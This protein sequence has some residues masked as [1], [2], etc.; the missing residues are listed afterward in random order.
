[1][2]D[3][4]DSILEIAKNCRHC[5]MC[6]VDFLNK[7]ICPAGLQKHY[8]SFYPVG[9]MDVYAGLIENTIPVTEKCLEIADS[10]NLCGKCDYQCY[11]VNELR[12]SKVM[13][14]LKDYIRVYLKNGGKII[15]TKDDEILLELKKVVGDFWA[16]NDPAIKI[17]YHHDL[18]PHVIFKMPKYIIM[19]NSKAEIVAV[20][21]I[22]QEH[23]ISFVVRG[24]GASTHGLV[25]TD[26]AVLDLNRMKTIEF[27][28]ENWH[29]KV[30][31]GVT[32]FELQTLAQQ[33][34]YRVHTAE[35]A[36]NVCANIM[37]SG[38]LSTFS[39]AYGI[40]AD[41]FVDAEFIT[42]DGTSFSLNKI[43]SPNF[44]AFDNY[45]TE[46][47]NKAICISVNMKLHPKTTDE[48]GMLIPFTTLENALDFA[49]DC[50]IRRIGLAIGIL[51]KEFTAVFLSPTKK[52]AAEV[53]ENFLEKLGMNYL[54]LLIGDKYALRAV[55]DMDLPIIDQE[56]FN[57][58]FLGLPALKSS[59]WL[60]LLHEFSDEKFSYL[61]IP[62]FKDLVAVAL[63]SSPEDL[64]KDL[65]SDLRDEF[66]KIYA[67]SE[68][69][70]LVW[71]NTFRILSSR[72]LRAKACVALVFYLAVDNKLICEI[73]DKLQ[74]I[75]KEN[76]LK[77]EF[78]FITPFDSGKRCVWEYDY[79]FAQNDPEDISR[80]QKAALAACE[81]LDKYSGKNGSVR[82][83]RYVVNQGC[84]RKENLLYTK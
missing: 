51:G 39:T 84:C 82:Q 37:C 72:F 19:P 6:K 53:K 16:T 83:L 79:Y 59:K 43:N 2:T 13:H 73:Y 25:F 28:K 46:K 63:D 70:N 66:A 38:I 58:L 34:N 10:C 14:A 48:E 27:D 3:F 1:M 23:N 31:P 54:V 33:H 47:N 69:S 78:G 49:K 65:D 68:M 12:P 44:F 36:A 76:N 56:L 8:A 26:G 32:A 61:K 60:N 30:G 52:L 41:N 4:N 64:V 57:I 40:S 17:A 29:V 67:R 75:A 81:L 62:H 9:R 50:A 5:A 11:F 42:K 35:P 20:I 7:G 80:V 15:S 74:K 24:N 21:K 45:L 18:C 77:N 22:L 55:K 71:L